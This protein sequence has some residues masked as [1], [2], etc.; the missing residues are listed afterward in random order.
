MSI[1][2][3]FDNFPDR[4]D[5]SFLKNIIK[6]RCLNAFKSIILSYLIMFIFLDLE[7][8]H[9]FLLLNLSIKSILILDA[10]SYMK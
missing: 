6:T 7:Y 2:K 10:L 5:Y 4:I 9:I 1:P 3:F 8:V